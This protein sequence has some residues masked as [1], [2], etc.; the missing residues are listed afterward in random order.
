MSAADQPGRRP[1]SAPPQPSPA[2]V[3]G[4]RPPRRPLPGAGAL[5][6]GV[7]LWALSVFVLPWASLN[8]AST[9]LVV[10]SCTG[11]AF[12]SVLRLGIEVHLPALGTQTAQT[13]QTVFLGV[14]VAG[15]VLIVLG[16]WSRLRPPWVY[17]LATVWLVAVALSG[18][19]A[20]DGVGVVVTQPDKVGLPAG[21]WS[22]DN[23]VLILVFA[24]IATLIGLIYLWV[25]LLQHHRR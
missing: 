9:P 24:V 8:C 16:L 10:G 11:V 3:A 7:V 20:R 13:A 21:G 17:S 6:L 5:M 22:G 12:D 25:D 15:A 4:G 2:R 19:L 14:L 1:A 18:W 23:G